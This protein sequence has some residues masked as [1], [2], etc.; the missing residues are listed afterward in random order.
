MMTGGEAGHGTLCSPQPTPMTD[1]SSP[2][3]ENAKLLYE[4]MSYA[5]IGAFFAVYNALG[6]GFLESVYRRAL[7]IELKRRGL[8]VEEEIG[9]VVHYLGQPVGAYRMDL[10]VEGKILVEIK[11]GKAL[12]EADRKQIFNYLR[13]SKIALGLLLHFGPKP[14]HKRFMS[15]I[16][17]VR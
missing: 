15:P 2:A 5:I 6:Y 17:N 11:A 8:R 10:V 16:F 3:P 13:A 14:D 4:D 7:I 12:V 1:L 9:V